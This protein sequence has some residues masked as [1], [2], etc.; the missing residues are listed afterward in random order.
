MP[1]S[2]VQSAFCP[3]LQISGRQFWERPDDVRRVHVWFRDQADAQGSAVRPRVPLQV[4]RQVAEGEFLAAIST[5]QWLLLCLKN[6][7]GAV[8]FLIP[9]TVRWF[10]SKGWQTRLKNNP[11]FVSSET[12]ETVG[13]GWR[14]NWNNS[15]RLWGFNV[16]AWGPIVEHDWSCLDGC[17]QSVTCLS[18]PWVHVGER[19][20]EHKQKQTQIK[21]LLHCKPYSADWPQ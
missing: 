8:C 4:C 3:F 5:C 12:A 16:L 19:E 6:H 7:L 13:N 18:Q 9:I 10:G 17:S 14:Q 21:H 11:P 15:T 20:L 1:G 2:Q